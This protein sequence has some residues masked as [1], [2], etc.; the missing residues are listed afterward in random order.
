MERVKLGFVGL[1]R[2]FRLGYRRWLGRWAR[3]TGGQVSVAA[4]SDINPDAGRRYE[5][6]LGARFFEDPMELLESGLVNAV[7]ISTPNWAHREQVEAA[8]RQGIHVLCEKPMARTYEECRSMNEACSSAGVTLQV[9]FMRRFSPAIQ[10]IKSMMDSEALG[11]I[12]EMNCNWPYFLADLDSPPWS[13]AAQLIERITGYSID[14]E[15]GA[16]R[17]KD[18]RCGGGDF[19]D[20]GPHI[21][22]LFT[23]FNG[24]ISH[25]SAESRV[26]APGR[27]EDFTCCRIKFENGAFGSI[28]TTLFDHSAGINGRVTGF[29]RGR[30][31]RINFVFPN[32]NYFLPIYFTH[33][34]ETGFT[35]GELARALG[36]RIPAPHFFPYVNL[37][38][39]QLEHFC[40]GLL[41]IRK[42][43][44]LFGMHDF[45]ANGADGAYTIKIV[46]AAYRSAASPPMWVA[47]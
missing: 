3:A 1:G 31:G 6:A 19:L 13:D 8:A 41:G 42:P 45:A 33:Y 14:R 16:W 40:S 37:F 4:L 2:I 34:G 5:S 46:E 22:D 15:W 28:T 30:R 43:H 25:V 7:V 21:C 17:L 29:I 26:M 11:E 39:A 9:S 35:A 38:K 18:P 44:P 36:V 12:I 32:T 47:V 27:N 10:K 23:W 20:H 24:R